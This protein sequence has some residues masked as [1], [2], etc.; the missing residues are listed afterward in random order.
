[1][2]PNKHPR[3]LRGRQ[4]HQRAVHLSAN[5]IATFGA[6][7][8]IICL[9]PQA[10]QSS[11][12]SRNIIVGNE[13]RQGQLNSEDAP[14]IPTHGPLKRLLPLGPCRLAYDCGSETMPNS[15]CPGAVPV[16][17]VKRQGLNLSCSTFSNCCAL[18]AVHTIYRHRPAQSHTIRAQL[19]HV[20]S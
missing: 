11:F 20:H 10:A 15:N 13:K 12:V 16:V 6:L 19:N 5:F 17:S 2:S 14:T 7:N 4:A 8:V 3:K 9:K 1:M 18:T